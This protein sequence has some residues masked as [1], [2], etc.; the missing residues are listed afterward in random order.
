MNTRSSIGAISGALG[1]MLQGPLV[2]K[3]RARY[4]SLFY[5]QIFLYLDRLTTK[6]FVFYHLDYD[7]E[8]SIPQ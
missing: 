3:Q 5:V 6:Y 4:F 8:F 1:G 2:T 7:M